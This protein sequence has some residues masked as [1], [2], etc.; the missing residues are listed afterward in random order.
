MRPR[1]PVIAGQL[2]PIRV[3]LVY[4]SAMSSLLVIIG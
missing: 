3:E 1:G 2:A 4:F